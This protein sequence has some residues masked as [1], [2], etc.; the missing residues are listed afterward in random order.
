MP[1]PIQGPLSSDVPVRTIERD[2]IR[3]KVEAKDQRFKLV[4][5]LADWEFRTK[6][7]PGSLHFRDASEML[8]ALRRDD[9]IVV[10][11]AN[12]PCLASVAAY[13]RFDVAWR[14]V[15]GLKIRYATSGTGGEKVVLFSPWPGK[16]LRLCPRVGRADEAVPG[17]GDR[18]SGLRGS[19]S[20]NLEKAGEGFAI[21]SIALGV[22][23][24]VAGS[25]L[26]DSKQSPRRSRR[27][28]RSRAKRECPLSKALAATPITLSGLDAAR[29]SNR[30]RPERK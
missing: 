2:E 5:A 14:T 30:S 1:I 18:S 29:C 16:H 21:T 15:D 25:T 8:S 17:A 12:P 7:I 28:A 9:E 23:A 4:M 6:H 26:L 11:C 10:Y 13:H 24:R 20:V 3:R 27:S 19:A 22:E